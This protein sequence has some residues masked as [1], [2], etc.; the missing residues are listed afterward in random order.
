MCDECTSAGVLRPFIFAAT[1]MMGTSGTPW[2][3]FPHKTP[4]APSCRAQNTQIWPTIPENPGLFAQRRSEKTD[5]PHHF[6]E[7]ESR[8]HSPHLKLGSEGA[9]HV[10]SFAFLCSLCGNKC[11]SFHPRAPTQC[12]FSKNMVVHG[13]LRG[14]VRKGPSYRGGPLHGP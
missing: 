7:N 4:N 5:V 9:P 1:R 14:G 2:C 6:G 10:M 8:H 3:H 11:D 13:S 12:V